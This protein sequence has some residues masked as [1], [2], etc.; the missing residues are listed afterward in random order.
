M[1]D[2]HTIHLDSL[3]STSNSDFIRH[4]FTPLNN[5]V[6]VSVVTANFLTAPTSPV[7]YLKIEELQTIYNDITGDQVT[8]GYNVVEAN[9]STQSVLRGSLAKF[10]VDRFGARTIY[11]QQDFS[12]QTQ[13]KH[14]LDRINRLTVKLY[15][16]NGDELTTP[17]TTFI[18][19]RFTCLK[20]TEDT[21]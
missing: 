3:S 12:T 6:Q 10:N 9:P 5:I 16:Q 7:A 1:Y 4:L 21:N 11:N 19:L 14:P 20:I 2:F 18:T 17:D 8:S 13:F 15:N